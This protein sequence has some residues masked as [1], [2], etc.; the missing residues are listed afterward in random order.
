VRQEI[1]LLKQSGE[2]EAYEIERTKKHHAVR[3]KA[4]GRWFTTVISA[5]PRTV[6]SNHYTRQNIR[7]T[8]R[9]LD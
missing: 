3:F 1:D 6:Y 5:S 7:R 8:L 2:I 9:T 4:K